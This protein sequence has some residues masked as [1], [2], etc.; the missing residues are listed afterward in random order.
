MVFAGVLFFSTLAAG[1]TYTWDNGGVTSDWSD[2]DNWTS[3]TCP[4]SGDIARFDGTSSADSVLDNGFAGSVLGVD[5]NAGYTGTIIQTA[6]L[7]IGASNYDQAAGTWIQGTTTMDI[8]SD[9]DFILSNGT[10]TTGVGVNTIEENITFSGGTLNSSSTR[11]FRFDGNSNFDDAALTYSGVFPATL[12]IAAT[13][14]PD[15]TINT[16]ATVSRIESSINLNAGALIIQSGAALHIGNNAVTSIGRFDIAGTTTASSSI[17]IIDNR[18]RFLGTGYFEYAGSDFTTEEGFEY[19]NGHTIGNTDWILTTDG[20]SNFDDGTI[21]TTASFPVPVAI[22]NPGGGAS[23]FISAGSDIILATSSSNGSVSIS[24]SVDTQGNDFTAS[25]I[26]LN[27]S[28]TTLKVAGH[29]TVTIPSIGENSTIEYTGSGT[30]SSLILGTNYENLSF[31]GGGTYNI[32]TSVTVEDNFLSTNNSTFNQT[33]GTFT[34]DGTSD[35]TVTGTSTF[36]NLTATAASPRTVTFGAGETITITG[37]TTLTGTD[38]TDYLAITSNL[39]GTQFKIDPQGGRIVSALQ[40]MDSN[41]INVSTITCDDNCLNSGNNTNWDIP[42]LR[43]KYRLQ[44]GVRFN[45]GI[46]F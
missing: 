34:L 41:N 44:G 15:F 30:Y 42:R 16:G 4:G 38:L 31:N 2:C 33:N 37:T 3:D 10:F 5:I 11:V 12:G 35:Q 13:L 1:A 8:N 14:S 25:S 40:V 43:E 46:R 21:T 9:G 28:V 29:E 6:D 23:M 27:G 22:N 17:N 24:G 18:V 20:S 32:S 36:A 39:P 19:Y 45:G 26:S 7:T